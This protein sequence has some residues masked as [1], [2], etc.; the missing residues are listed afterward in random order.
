MQNIVVNFLYIFC[1]FG[2]L[3]GI[4]DLLEFSYLCIELDK[5]L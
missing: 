4:C 5:K 2:W 1:R 3:W